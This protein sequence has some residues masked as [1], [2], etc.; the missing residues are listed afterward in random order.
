MTDIATKPGTTLQ[1]G[2]I[3]LAEKPADDERGDDVRSTVVLTL[4]PAGHLP[5]VTW[6]RWVTFDSPTATGGKQ[7]VETCAW[8]HY[9]ATL[10]EALADFNKRSH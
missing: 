4:Q 2:A 10:D 5:F 7:T 8:G 9:H 1:N 6:S 3:L